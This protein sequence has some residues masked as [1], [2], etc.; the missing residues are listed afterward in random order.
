MLNSVGYLPNKRTDYP[1]LVE[2]QTDFVDR[3]E[4]SITRREIFEEF[5]KFLEEFNKICTPRRL[6]IDGSFATGKPNPNDIDVVIFI[7]YVHLRNKWRQIKELLVKQEGSRLDI[8]PITEDNDDER[9]LLTPDNHQRIVE[10]IQY[11][12]ELFSKDR[13]GEQKGF[14]QIASRRE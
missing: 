4:T 12:E 3:F 14:V 6:W 11:W 13:N 9:E 10:N 7:D 5:L 1:S 2:F 8:F